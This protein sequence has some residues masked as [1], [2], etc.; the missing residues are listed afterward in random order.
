VERSITRFGVEDDKI[1]LHPIAD[2]PAVRQSRR[3]AGAEVILRIA[4]SNGNQCCSRANLP[5]HSRK[6]P[7]PRGGAS[8]FTIACY[9]H[10]TLNV[11]S[12]TSASFIE[13]HTT[14]ARRRELFAGRLQLA[15]M[16]RTGPDFFKRLAFKLRM[17]L[18]VGDKHVVGSSHV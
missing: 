5:S 7:E 18:A 3:A 10:P 15:V 12:M 1:S 9:H 13:L 2:Q 4:S 16:F 17:R 6:V 14:L 8:R 11:E